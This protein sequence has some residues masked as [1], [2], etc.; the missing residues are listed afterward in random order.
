MLLEDLDT[1]YARTS[2]GMMHYRQHSGGGKKIVFIH[3]FAAS[4]KSWV[5]L[6][7]ELPESL[8][9]CFVDLLGHGLSDAPKIEYTVAN[10]AKAI[11]EFLA[12]KGMQDA[13][14]FGHSYGGWVAAQLAQS[15]SGGAGMILEDA[16][17]LQ[18]YFDDLAR[19][20]L[21]KSFNERWRE[22]ARILGM[23]EDVAESAIRSDRAGEAL[24]E[25][26]LSAVSVPALIIW[27]DGDN[28]VPIKYAQLFSKYIKGSELETLAGAGH[29]PH[30]TNAKQVAEL[31]LHFIGR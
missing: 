4:T 2:L 10:Q 13:Y 26:S 3:G 8:D 22:E 30:Y 31:L 16:M 1:G 25:A 23:G 7:D 14:L 18:D 19:Q 27:G 29:V 24:T 5:R 21:T 17:G 28:I 11:N 20:D 9:M 12:L 15:G 6:V